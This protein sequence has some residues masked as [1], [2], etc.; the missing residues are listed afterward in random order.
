[1][2]NIIFNFLLALVVLLITTAAF[3]QGV[4][5]P[6]QRASVPADGRMTMT[7]Y[8]YR[9]WGPELVNYTVDTAKFHPGALVL[10]DGA[11]KAVPF[12]IDG[13]TLSYVAAVPDGGTV[14]YTLQPSAQ[15]RAK[16]NGTLTVNVANDVLELGNEFLVLRMPAPG[17]KTYDPAADAAT[18]PAPLA[19]WNPGSQGWMGGAHFNTAHKVASAAFSLVRQGPAVV[20]YEARYRFA[21]TGE[22]VWRLRLSPG[23]PIAIVTEEFDMGAISNGEDQLVLDL[24]REWTPANLGW[25]AGSGEQQLPPLNVSTYDA[26][27]AQRMKVMPDRA[28][29]GGVGEQPAP[30]AP[31]A[32]A[33]FLEPLTVAG[34]WGANKGGVQVWDGA[35]PGAGRNIG[36]VTLSDG[37]WRRAMSMD[38]WYQAGAGV[39]VALP[40][41]VRYLRWSLEVT[42]DFS[43]FSTHEHDAGLKETYGRRVWG[44]YTG[45]NMET[46]QARF[47]FI[48]LDRYKDWLIDVPEGKAAEGAYPGA[49]FKAAFVK[50]LRD[51]IDGHPQADQLKTRYLISGKTED[52]IHNAEEV[53]ARLKHPY[54]ENDFFVVGL[55][56]YRK[57]Q[58]LMPVNRAEDALACPDLPTALRQELRRRLTLYAYVTSDPDWNPRGAGV[59]LGN[60]NMPINRTLALSLF[61]PLLPDHPRY[62]YWMEQIRNFVD[63]KLHSQFAV[64]GANIECPTYETYAPAQALNISLNVLR[65]RGFA[66]QDVLEHYKRNLLFLANLAMPDP[67]YHGARIIPGMGNSSNDQESIWG[68]SEATFL[69]DDPQFAGWLHFF[70]GLAGKHFGAETTGVTS[71]GHAMYYLPGLPDNPQTLA[72]TFFPTYGV[73]FRNHFNTP[74]ETAML[75]RAGMNWG[76]W[77]TDALNTI[78]YAKGAPLSPGTGYQYYSGP[79]TA[80][81]AI[82]HNQMKLGTMNTQECFGRVDATIT[83]YGFGPHAD[84]ALA[85]RYYPRQIFADKG[86]ATIWNRHILFVKSEQADGDDYFVMRDTF[87]GQMRKSWWEWMNLDTADLISVDGQA[88]DPNTTAIDKI[89]PEEQYPTLRGQTLEMKTKYGASTWFWFSEPC[90]IRTRMTF[91]AVGETK[92][93]VDIP[94]APGQDY[95]YLVFPR[96]DGAPTPACTQLAP[97]MMRVTTAESTDYLFLGDAPFNWEEDGIVFTGKAGAIRIYKDHVVLSMNAG[98]GRIGYKGDI[99]AGNGPFEQVINGAAR[100]RVTKLTDGYEKKMQSVDLGNGLQVYGEAPFTAALDGETLHIHTQGRARVLHVT[101]PP[102]LLRPQYWIDGEEWMACWTD[103]PNNGWGAYDNSSLIGLSVPDGTHNLLVK[104]QTFPH[105]WTRPFTPLIEGEMVGK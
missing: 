4:T 2:R 91:K 46:A 59:H 37:S 53:I 28:Q 9:D 40:I 75:F 72:T 73:V 48:G 7:D 45:G 70:F 14:T 23:M 82:Y 55:T 5:D 77:D 94:G 80:D 102:F 20:E 39:Q 27:I 103:Y 47:G 30:H 49:L 54:Q 83:D 24:H 104:N 50:G 13:N 74:N 43:P 25:V 84:Y 96:K 89:I 79:A 12:Q 34:R 100:R 57:V 60:N 38:T 18:V 64:D 42:D 10:L 26:Y 52:A 21:P 71:V 8:G 15:D 88:F 31:A 76:H 86:E 92:T 32:G 87:S 65:N 67:R 35:Q 16:E 6:M 98:S 51:A 90:D 97:G 105:G 69:Q 68:V 19:Q 36:V 99:F 62:A 44:L 85:S 11:G 1:M 61:A 78:L 95:F 56:N 3:S 93:I 22:Y 63:F 58:L 101:Q 17:T 29:V 33:L 81:N 66:Y 41:S